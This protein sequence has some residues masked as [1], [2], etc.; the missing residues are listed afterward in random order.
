MYHDDSPGVYHLCRVL[1]MYDEC[2]AFLY[3]SGIKSF[4]DAALTGLH[5]LTLYYCKWRLGDARAFLHLF[6]FLLFNH[7]MVLGGTRNLTFLRRLTTFLVL[8]PGSS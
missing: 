7:Q 6:N 3:H 1:I 4:I 2:S 5:S 8:P